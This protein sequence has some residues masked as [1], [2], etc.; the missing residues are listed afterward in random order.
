MRKLLVAFSALAFATCLAFGMSGTAV[1]TS[2]STAA[3]LPALERILPQ[4][5][6]RPVDWALDQSTPA[7]DIGST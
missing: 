7:T 1:A 2:A 4:S 6:V 3:T 5:T